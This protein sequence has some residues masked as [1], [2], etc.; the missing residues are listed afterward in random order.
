MSWARLRTAT[1]GLLAPGLL[2]FVLVALVAYANAR[3][4]VE[5]VF[6][7]QA[8]APGRLQVFNDAEGAF[9]ET[10]SQW[11][12]LGDGRADD[13][14]LRLSGRDAGRLRLDPPLA[15]T[16]RVCNLRIGRSG[17]ADQ[18]E[19]LHADEISLTR[20]QACLR[21]QP[22]PGARDPKLI[23]RFVDRS[24]A[25]IER[26]GTWQRVFFATAFALLLALGWIRHFNRARLQAAIAAL[27]VLPGFA[28]IDRRAHWFCAAMML[29]FGTAQVF[30]TPPGA[31][32]DEEAHFAKIVRI[33]EGVVVGGSG[34]TPMP[35]TRAMYGPFWS[36]PTNK[37]AFTEEQLQAQLRQ[38]LRCTATSTTLPSG[39]DG[40]F[41]H[42]YV[43]P[44]LAFKAGCAA[45][46]S[47]GWFLYVARLLNLLLAVALVAWGLRHAVRGK[48]ALFVVA[49]LPMSLFQMGSLSADS[50]TL[51]LSLAW[52]GLLSGIAGGAVNVA[53][54]SP[55]LW[56]LGLA[57]A[58]LKPGSAWIL[59][60]LLFC[61]PAFDA[62]GRS[63]GAALAKHVALPWLIH[64]AWTL[65]AA[66]GA[67][68]LAGVDAAANLHS[69][70]AD[71]TVFLRAWLNTFFSDRVVPLIRM[72]IGLLGWLDVRLSPW[73]YSV[74]GLA[75]LATLWTNEATLPRT[76]R[77]V[78]ALSLLFAAGSLVLVALPL[79]IYWSPATLGFIQGLQGRYFTA[80]AAF[81]LV[82]CSFR[83]PEAI[84]AVLV[85][86]AV[87]GIA[88]INVDALQQLHD[89]YF[90][91][92]RL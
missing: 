81:V 5:V 78:F 51:S 25:K 64:V 71:P 41:L 62:A 68:P 9:S 83:S 74:G 30:G 13:R 36:Y 1:S 56:T 53:R 42:Q 55:A 73:A 29:V 86:A 2:L 91:T 49:L 47:F 22:V 40:Y 16:T 54:A 72:M 3:R 15:A 84:R 48:W 65:V 77:A 32:A 24:A 43:L 85:A 31:V 58:L 33:S 17:S 11:F 88:A 60:C 37:A 8:S 7:A 14:S 38:P 44:A 45:G 61:K 10:R 79:F 18:F 20:E 92:G 63:F 70:T 59:A 34:A 6:A 50:L 76:P 57:I 89:A 90:V 35:D 46:A 52:L 39:A 67:A 21:L 82:W 75:L 80:T 87:L 26:A 19:I 28:A 12:D 66:K 23:V 69:L 27:P 4:H